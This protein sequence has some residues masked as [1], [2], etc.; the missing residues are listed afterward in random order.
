MN[1]GIEMLQYFFLDVLQIFLD[2]HISSYNIKK[3]GNDYNTKKYLNSVTQA[4]QC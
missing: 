2:S 3:T 1:A 4:A